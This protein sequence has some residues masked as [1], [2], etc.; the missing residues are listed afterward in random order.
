MDFVAICGNP[1]RVQL[2]GV[3]SEY[4]LTRKRGHDLKNPKEVVTFQGPKGF[5]I[6]KISR[7]L[8][9]SFATRFDAND[10]KATN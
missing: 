8:L 4:V 7:R 5:G 10:V 1:V 9:V 6:T 3:L 2:S